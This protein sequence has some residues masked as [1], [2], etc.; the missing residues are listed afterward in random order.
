[1]CWDSGC[2]SFSTCLVAEASLVGWSWNNSNCRFYSTSMVEEASIVG[3]DSMCC[4]SNRLV[5]GALLVC[6]SYDS[7]CFSTG[8]GEE[9]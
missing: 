7:K 1:M 2:G 5:E 3:C 6:R 4:F 9:A 8:L